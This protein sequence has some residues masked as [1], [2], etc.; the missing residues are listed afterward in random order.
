[1]TAALAALATAVAAP[2]SASAATYCAATPGCGNSDL[3]Q[4]L[5]WAKSS[6]GPD[7]VEVGPGRFEK[8]DGF[9]YTTIDD[10]NSVAIVGA[11]EA[12]VLAPTQ[13]SDKSRTAL[14]LNAPGSSVSSLRLESIG[15]GGSAG[16]SYAL[17]LYHGSA[18]RV[19]LVDALGASGTNGLI[20]TDAVLRDADVAADE[21]AVIGGDLTIERS[22]LEGTGGVA[23]N[24]PAPSTISE[25]AIDALDTG[26]RASATSVSCATSSYG[27]TSRGS[28]CARTTSAPTPRR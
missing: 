3:Q 25:T 10:A 8:T 19:A 13:A 21:W 4:A 15:A 28:R 16:W 27:C 22:R 12:T 23:L 1:M 24:P 9:T 7:R 14:T 26:V 17:G 5:N 6:A 20:A 18:E 11:G 2:A